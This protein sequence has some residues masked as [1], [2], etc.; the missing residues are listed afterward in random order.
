MPFGSVQKNKVVCPG[1]NGDNFRSVPVMN[2]RPLRASERREVSLA[3]RQQSSCSSIPVRRARG[4]ASSMPAA[5]QPTGR[6]DFQYPLRIQGSDGIKQ[7]AES[8]RPGDGN[9]PRP[10]A[11]PQLL[12][13]LPTR[14]TSMMTGRI[15][16][17]FFVF[18][19]M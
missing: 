12:Q 4:A 9:A 11:F 17:F 18:L 5:E 8:L 3:S 15:M 6:S 10:R 2:E 16:G 14:H 19:K 7:E 13:F 1:K